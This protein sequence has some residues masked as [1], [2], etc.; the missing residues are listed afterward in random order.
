M[1][2]NP[3]TGLI[4]IARNA[5]TAVAVVTLALV[6]VSCGRSDDSIERDVRSRLIVDNVTSALNLTVTA[7]DGTVRVSGA[8]K[9]RRQ[10]ERAIE[11]AREVAGSA[12]K[13]INEI[14]LDE[15]PLAAAVYAAAQQDPVTATV[16]FDVEVFERGIVVLRSDRTTEAQ[17]T[18]L[19][20]IAS[21]V[22]GVSR[23]DAYMK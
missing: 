2:V 19:L 7:Q 9:T 13:V 8:A 18:R 23:V 20:E 12:E 10:S 5:V 3:E 16:P 15:S 22:P 21:K 11:I 14:R 4:S 1:P 17:R 6:A